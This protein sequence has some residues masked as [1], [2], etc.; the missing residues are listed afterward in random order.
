MQNA[1]VTSPVDGFVAKRHVNPGAMVSQQTSGRVSRR[2]I[3]HLKLIVNVVEKTC[4]LV[5]AGTPAMSRSTP[6]R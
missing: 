1:T 2:G 4:R 3:S 6:T 5:D